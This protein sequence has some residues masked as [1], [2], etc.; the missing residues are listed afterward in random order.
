MDPIGTFGFAWKLLK[1]NR[2]ASWNARVWAHKW[3]WSGCPEKSPIP[4]SLSSGPHGFPSELYQWHL[5]RDPGPFRK[6]ERRCGAVGRSRERET[7]WG[8]FNAWSGQWVGPTF[9]AKGTD[10]AI[11]ELVRTCEP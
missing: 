5:E 4:I 1:F 7:P 9:N 2:P 3:T 11:E 8:F 10:V 6:E